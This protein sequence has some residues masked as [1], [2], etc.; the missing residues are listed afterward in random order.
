MKRE[1]VGIKAVDS[2]IEGGFPSGSVIG[3]S[4]PPGVGKSIFGLHFLLEGARKGQKGIY[5]SLEEP[6]RNIDNMI[7][8]F[9]FEKEFYD[10]EK[11]GLIVI[12]NFNYEEYENINIE[13]LE[14]IHD[15]EKIK[16]VVIDSFNCFFDSLEGEHSREIHLNVRK[17]INQSFKYLR[18]EG[19]NVLLV[20]EENENS[21]L[22]F[23]YNIPYLVDGIVKLNYL[24]LGDIERRLIIPKMR[25][26][27]QLK[28]S[29]PYGINNDGIFI[30]D[31]IEI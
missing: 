20:L 31:S 4:G 6:R 7:K 23:D 10:F 28:E 13:L 3:I 12:K 30:K 8:S 15:N 24:E 21:L 5:V 9:S 29:V 11:K 27:R 1:S 17:L 22:S 16:R 19:L 14:K 2:M 26:T 25:W 18:K